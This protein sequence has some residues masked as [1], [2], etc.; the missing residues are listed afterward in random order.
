MAYLNSASHTLTNVNLTALILLNKDQAVDEYGVTFRCFT[1][2][3][4][5]S[6]LAVNDSVAT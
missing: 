1:V 2:L 5:L 3:Q 6:T 4:D